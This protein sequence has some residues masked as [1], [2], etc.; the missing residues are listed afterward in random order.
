M[1]PNPALEHYLEAMEGAGIDAVAVDTNALRI[2][3]DGLDYVLVVAEDE[4]TFFQ[5]MLPH[6]WPLDTHTVRSGVLEAA[7]RVMNRLKAVKLLLQ[8]D[9]I[10]VSVEQFVDTPELGASMVPGMIELINSATAELH[11][12]L[13]PGAAPRLH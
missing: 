5:L 3:R 2:S 6:A 1:Q 7:N 13:G 11:S 10:H 9:A 12:E 8:N 4:S